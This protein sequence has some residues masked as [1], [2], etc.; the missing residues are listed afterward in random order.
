MLHVS[1]LDFPL[2]KYS[3]KGI[4]YLN[5]KNVNFDI[6]HCTHPVKHFPVY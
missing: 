5:L 2:C 3:L 4:V 1:R 6:V